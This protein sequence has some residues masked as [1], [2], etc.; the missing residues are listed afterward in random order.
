M[1]IELISA[2]AEKPDISQAVIS[3]GWTLIQHNRYTERA[4]VEIIDRKYHC[5]AA[6]MVC[7]Q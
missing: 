5:M 3:A 4:A 2:T 1:H 6:D 7:D